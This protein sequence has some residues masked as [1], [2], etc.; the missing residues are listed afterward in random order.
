M[1]P[2]AKK[3]FQEDPPALAQTNDN[4]PNGAARAARLANSDIMDDPKT[5]YV[6][7]DAG[8]SRP[9]FRGLDTITDRA[10]CGWLIMIS[11]CVFWAPILVGTGSRNGPMEATA[12]M[13][14][15]TKK[16]ERTA[17]IP[18]ETV[19]EIAQVMGQP[20]YNCGRVACSAELQQRNSAVRAKLGGLLATKERSDDPS[21][22]RN[23]RALS[24]V[25]SR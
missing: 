14:L 23:H 11:A 5:T 4:V 18:T 21:A 9:A 17:G 15:L 19:S 24:V 12:Q 10:L 25:I 6:W 3:F 13:E 8:L 22:S 1:I 7:L 2:A 20:W 16:L